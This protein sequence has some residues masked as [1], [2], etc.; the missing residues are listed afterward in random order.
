MVENTKGSAI[1]KGQEEHYEPLPNNL[2]QP[3]GNQAGA[4]F[5]Q[6]RGPSADYGRCRRA[7][8]DGNGGAKLALE[9]FVGADIRQDWRLMMAPA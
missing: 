7:A 4:F 6:P 9:R 1:D 3:T 8:R 2:I 5:I